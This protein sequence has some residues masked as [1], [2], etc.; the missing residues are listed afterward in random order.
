MDVFKNQLAAYFIIYV[1]GLAWP[2]FV[3]FPRVQDKLKVLNYTTIPVYLPE[4][5]IGAHQSD[6][7]FREFSEVRLSKP[8][9]WPAVGLKQL[10]TASLL[11]KMVLSGCCFDLFLFNERTSFSLKWFS[12][13]PFIL[14]CKADTALRR[15]GHEGED[16][17][18]SVRASDIPRQHVILV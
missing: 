16:V 2:M 12:F 7:V 17:L 15:P 3:L 14:V 6:R 18:G 13:S 9:S 5:T 4:I 11:W 8:E 10:G 1:D